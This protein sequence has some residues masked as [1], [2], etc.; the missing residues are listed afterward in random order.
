MRQLTWLKNMSVKMYYLQ[1]VYK[2]KI[3][4]Y[5]IPFPGFVKNSGF[6]TKENNSLENLKVTMSTTLRMR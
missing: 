1:V 5:G 4:F 3:M 2:V 6:Y